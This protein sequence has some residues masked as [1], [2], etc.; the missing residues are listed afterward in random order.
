[1]YAANYD[2]ALSDEAITMLEDQLPTVST[3]GN[4]RFATNIMD[5]A[6]QL[7]ALRLSDQLEQG[8]NPDVSTISADDIKYVLNGYRR[9]FE[10]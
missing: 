4:G 2:Y 10:G 6:V 1:M 8:I 3:D 5:E 7:Q 9:K